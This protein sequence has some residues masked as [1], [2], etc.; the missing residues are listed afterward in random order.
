ML[1]LQE[2]QALL[3]LLDLQRCQELTIEGN[4]ADISKEYACGL[5]EIG[6]NRVSLG[7]QSFLDEELKLLGRRS[8]SRETILAFEHLRAAGLQNISCDLM[9]GLPRQTLPELEK[10]L[11]GLLKLRPEHISAYLLTLD[12]G[13]AMYCQRGNLP[14]DSDLELFYKQIRKTLLK[15]GYQQYELSNFC[16]PGYESMHNMAYWQGKEYLALGEGGCSYYQEGQNYFRTDGFG[17][18]EELTLQKRESE[19]IFLS[20]RLAQ[21]LSLLKYSQK[22]GGDFG[23]KYKR[24]LQKYENFLLINDQQVALLPKAYFVADE[25][26]AEFVSV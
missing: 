12:E 11:Q 17:G 9:Y 22:F 2:L 20:L 15:A 19:F 1:S 26:M 5:K 23:Q 18:K 14:I 7:L 21:G 13:V 3:A 4:P 10:S 6:F 8:N 25:I 16:L 24:I